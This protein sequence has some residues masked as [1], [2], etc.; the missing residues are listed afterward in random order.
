MQNAAREAEPVGRP[1][2]GL[3]R[4]PWRDPP[5]AR[6]SEPFCDRPQSRF[7]LLCPWTGPHG[8]HTSYSRTPLTDIWERYSRDT[9]GWQDQQFYPVWPGPRH[10]R[11][12]IVPW[13]PSPHIV[14]VVIRHGMDARAQILPAHITYDNLCRAIRFQTQWDPGE[15]RL[16]PALV[17]QYRFD[18][19]AAP[20][21]AHWRCP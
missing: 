13:P 17:C 18:V 11:L 10:D 15:V 19:Q 20:R 2:Y 1:I 12:S 4:Y 8:V 16:P 21:L 5:G 9:P 3:H 6:T 14:C 7:T